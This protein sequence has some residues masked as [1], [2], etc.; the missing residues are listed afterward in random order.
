MS[1][2]LDVS[3]EREGAFEVPILYVD[4]DGTVRHGLDELGHFVNGP[5]DVVVFPE[6]IEQLRRWRQEVGGRVIGV[7]NQGGIAKGYMTGEACSAAM[8]ATYEATEGLIDMIAFCP[9]EP[10]APDPENR[11]WC[12]KPRAG[13][14]IEGTMRL[15]MAY[16]DERYPRHLALFVGDRK[17][18]ELCASAANVDFVWAKDWRAGRWLAAADRRPPS[19]VTPTWLASS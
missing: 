9:H 1:Y 15:E 12:R 17:E 13:L 11:C 4:L 16:P 18:D 19:P 2:E 8:M 3:D 6:A 7:S 5:E 10:T 14:V